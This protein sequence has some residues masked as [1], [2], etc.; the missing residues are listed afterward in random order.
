M[1][2]VVTISNE[3]QYIPFTFPNDITQQVSKGRLET[4]S[5]LFFHYLYLSEGGLGMSR[6]PRRV[7][8]TKLQHSAGLQNL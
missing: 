7:A 3:I 4:S 1:S 6:A 8:S 5:E 2:L